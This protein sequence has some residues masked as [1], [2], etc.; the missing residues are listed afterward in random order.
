M[1]IPF[2]RFA[3][4]ESHSEREIKQNCKLAF[5]S[6][7]AF[8]LFFGR[9][10]GAAPKR[11]G[12][13]QKCLWVCPETLWNLLEASRDRKWKVIFFMFSP[14]DPPTC[15]RLA[16]AVTPAGELGSTT[17]E[18]ATYSSCL[19]LPSDL[20]TPRIMTPIWARTLGAGAS[21]RNFGPTWRRL[22]SLRTL[23][24]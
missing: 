13:L 11:T 21:S 8:F 1:Y 24:Y 20:Q 3:T 7:N 10:S 18:S 19:N 9:V 6:A 23:L 15:K 5:Y 4:P 17:S 14:G 16:C 12:R 2:V 22:S